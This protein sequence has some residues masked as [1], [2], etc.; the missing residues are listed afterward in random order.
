MHWTNARTTAARRPRS[1]SAAWPAKDGVDAAPQPVHEGVGRPAGPAPEAGPD[2]KR[3]PP[4]A[5]GAEEATA[6]DAEPPDEE[7]PDPRPG[8]L[9]LRHADRA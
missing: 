4:V 5:I 1:V 9:R 2:V 3:R 7:A 8:L 6:P